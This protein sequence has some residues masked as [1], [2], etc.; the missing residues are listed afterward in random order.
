MASGIRWRWSIEPRN[1]RKGATVAFI[2]GTQCLEA[3]KGVMDAGRHVLELPQEPILVRSTLCGFNATWNGLT[4]SQRVQ[5]GEPVAGNPHGEF[6]EGG[7]VQEGDPQGPSLPTMSSCLPW[8]ARGGRV[9]P[10]RRLPPP[11]RPR[12]QN[13]TFT[14]SALRESAMR[15][16][17]EW[18]G[19]IH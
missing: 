4:S 1:E 18:F 6:C 11:W 15:G 3:V 13:P 17:H 9:I 19:V 12:P 10:P 16:Q 14:A 8:M 7:R 2:S 5:P